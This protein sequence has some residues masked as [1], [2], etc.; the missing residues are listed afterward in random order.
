MNKR[1][2][3]TPYFLDG[4]RG[5][6]KTMMQDEWQLNEVPPAGEGAD[7]QQRVVPYYQRIAEFV[8]ETAAAGEVP[9]SLAGDCCM[10][11]PVLKGLQAAGIQPTLLWLDAHG[12]FNTWETTPSGFLGGMP[13][14]MMVGRG[15]QTWVEALEMELLPEEKV[16]FSDGRDL[17]PEELINLQNSGVQW[18]KDPAELLDRPLPDNLWVHFDTDIMRLSDA[19]AMSYPAEG[20]PELETLR[21]LFRRLRESGKIAAV[22]VSMWNPELEGADISQANAMALVEELL[23]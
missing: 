21:A 11:L 23:G 6:Y 12:D 14:A 7:I 16:I 18:V 1:I 20:G 4:E 5:Q 13:L 15:E 8:Q 17:D 2:L 22:S 3:L 9:V 10:S 19:P